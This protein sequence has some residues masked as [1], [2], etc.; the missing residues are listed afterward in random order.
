M[1]SG[2]SDRQL[3]DPGRQ[4]QRPASQPRELLG[5]VPP[6]A[7]D[8]EL[9]LLGSMLINPRLPFEELY[10]LLTPADFYNSDMGELFDVMREHALSGRYLDVNTLRAALADRG[11]WERIG[12]ARTIVDITTAASTG[13]HAMY[14]A[15]RI[16]E[17]STRRR[18]IDVGSGMIQEAYDTLGDTE[19]MVERV[20][21]EVY[22]V[23]E[24]RLEPRSN[25]QD[26]RQAIAEIFESLD[27]DDSD[28]DLIT[29]GFERLDLA[30][31]G[32]RRREMVVIGARPGVGKSSF[33]INSALPAAEAGF[34]VLIYSLEMSADELAHRMIAFYSDVSTFRMRRGHFSNDERQAIVEAGSRIS[35]LGIYVDDTP[36]TTVG[37][38][39]A[40]IRRRARIPRE[41][42]GGVDLI[43][44]DYLQLVDADPGEH[45]H[46]PRH[47]VIGKI[48]RRLR[49]IAREVD[50]ALVILAQ[51]NRESGQLR[52]APRLS[53]LRESGSIEQDADTVLFLHRPDLDDHQIQ[54]QRRSQGEPDRAELIVAKQ[55]HGP[56]AK[57]DMAFEGNRTRYVEAA[58]H[59]QNPVP[60]ADDEE[61]F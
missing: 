50:A 3:T 5:R 32:Y 61:P 60:G 53:E 19:A 38:I 46:T 52:R 29:T 21:S 25:Q 51:V 41:R 55:R 16:H 47:E 6:A 57:I 2:P 17:A 12:G 54:E 30:I 59:Q 26:V 13:A 44:I 1:S 35:Q 58:P 7:E 8:S 9:A 34:R 45:R 39:G 24:D 33:A 56:L 11:A 28:A 15:Q 49:T 48:T 31:G 4:A 20:A 43:M 22:R 18:L 10:E 23:V 40:G 36:R 37:Q 42:N 27:N 14:H